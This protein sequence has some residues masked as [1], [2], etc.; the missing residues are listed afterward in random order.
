MPAPH[1][2]YPHH[3]RRSAQLATYA[4]D[5]CRFGLSG[6]RPAGIAAY[7]RNADELVL[8]RDLAIFDGRYG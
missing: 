3:P 1:E 7:G 2:G 6:E 8:R 4:F 5:L